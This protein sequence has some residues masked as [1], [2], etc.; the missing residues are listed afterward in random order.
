MLPNDLLSQMRNVQAVVSEALDAGSEVL[1]VHVGPASSKVRV[2][3]GRFTNQF[4]STACLDPLTG[5]WVREVHGTSV[6]WVSATPQV[7]LFNKP[8]SAHAL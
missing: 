8:L 4:A 6:A 5:E 7:S 1:A 2:L 3:P